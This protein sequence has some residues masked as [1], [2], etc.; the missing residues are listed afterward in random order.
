M[1]I[2]KILTV[3]TIVFSICNCISQHA[4]L[5]ISWQLLDYQTDGYYGASVEKAYSQ[6]LKGK[7]PKK[8]II[9][10]VIDVGVDITHPALK[11]MI[12]TNAKE[13]PNNGKDDDGN[14]YIEDVNGWNFM[15]DCSSETYDCVREYV[16]FRR[17]YEKSVDT[18]NEKAKF[19]RQMQKET[20]LKVAEWQRI[21]KVLSPITEQ[22]EVLNG[23]WSAIL[24]KDTVYFKE[25]SHR[26]MADGA[27]TDQINA[28]SKLMAYF[29]KRDTIYINQRTLSE[30]RDYYKEALALNKREY[31]T[32]KAIIDVNDVDLFRKVSPGD[33]SYSNDDIY[34]GNGDVSAVNPH[35]TGCAGIIAS[36][37]TNAKAQGITNAVEIMPIKVV[38]PVVIGEERDKDVANAIRYAVNNGAKIINY[39]IGKPQSPQKQWVD[40]AIKYAEKNGVLIMASAGNDAQDNDVVED[41]IGINFLDGSKATNVLKVG[42]STFTSDLVSSFSNYGQES[43]TI[44]APGNTITTLALDGGYYTDSGTSFAAPML[45]GIAAMIWNYYPELSYKQV[46]DCLEKSVQY[47]DVMVLKPGADVKV[48]LK[49]LCSSGGMV[50]A[51]V[52]IQMAQKTASK[53]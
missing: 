5:P 43:V 19:W 13:I 35:G 49:N 39:S 15:G 48:P 46:K 52:A 30:I 42:S 14:G 50:N 53:K 21:I 10:A 6:L 36:L 38:T 26:K 11:G 40:D 16:K 41:Y 34:Y 12:W 18:L 44:F 33:N 47:A 4:K 37:R 51:F 9:V 25:I 28:Q 7:K 20:D 29:L 1:M 45:C 23:Y 24:K 31:E 32:A 8:K 22:L 27:T 2:K 17:E 3:I